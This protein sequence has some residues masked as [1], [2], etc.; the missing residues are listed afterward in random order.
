M[1][2]TLL[3]AL[4]IGL[5]ALVLQYF[6][7][8]WT[9]VI[10]GAVIGMVCSGRSLSAFWSGFLGVGL[11][12]MVAALYIHLANDALLTTRVAGMMG[13]PYPSLIILMTTLIGALSGALGGLTGYY[14]KSSARSFMYRAPY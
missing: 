6:L 13:L 14:L 12:W 4:Y 8:W 11:L 7:P 1:K 10:A 5:M 3:H 9:A 2:S